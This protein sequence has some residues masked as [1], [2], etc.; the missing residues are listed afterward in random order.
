MHECTA[1]Q[2]LYDSKAKVARED[3]WDPPR[4][5]SPNG[6]RYTSLIHDY[7]IGELIL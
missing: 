5:N 3:Y 7:N 6:T 1:F 2:E 4:F